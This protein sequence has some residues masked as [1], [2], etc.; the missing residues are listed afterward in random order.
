MGQDLEL[1]KK[2]NEMSWNEHSEEWSPED[3]SDEELNEIK[4]M[5]KLTETKAV[6]NPLTEIDNY[7]DTI[8]EDISKAVGN[9]SDA[10]LRY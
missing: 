6:P 10:E 4:E 8:G 2:L 3:V 1:D 5:L 7:I 9:L